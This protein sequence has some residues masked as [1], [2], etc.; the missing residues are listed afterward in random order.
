[1]FLLEPLRNQHLKER[2]NPWWLTCKIF[3]PPRLVFVLLELLVN[4]ATTQLVTFKVDC[5]LIFYAKPVFLSIQVLR[6]LVRNVSNE[7]A[8]GGKINYFQK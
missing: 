8:R 4:T 1:M 3:Y 6:I 2:N 7:Q 5:A